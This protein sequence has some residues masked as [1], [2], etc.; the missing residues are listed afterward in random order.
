ME[1]KP[2]PTECPRC[3]AKKFDGCD[4]Y[5]WR[6]VQK[7]CATE[8]ECITNLRERIDRIEATLERHNF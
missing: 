2:M 1:E 6:T 5:E 7:P 4:R 8:A 3:G